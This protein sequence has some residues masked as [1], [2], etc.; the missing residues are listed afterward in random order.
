MEEILR[1]TEFSQRRLGLL[2]QMS[3]NLADRALIAMLSR[4]EKLCA[5]YAELFGKIDETIVAE[6]QFLVGR[7]DGVIDIT[8]E[9]AKYLVEIW[10]GQHK[11]T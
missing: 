11:V 9:E 6:A 2:I 8:G 7:Y 4:Q 3:A 5:K 1:E 10:Q